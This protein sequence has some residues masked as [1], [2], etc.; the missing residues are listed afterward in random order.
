MTNITRTAWKVQPHLLFLLK[1]RDVPSTGLH[2]AEGQCQSKY[3][4]VELNQGTTNKDHH[5]QAEMEDSQNSTQITG[6]TVVKNLTWCWT[7]QWGTNV[8]K[9][10]GRKKSCIQ[11]LFSNEHSL[12]QAVWKQWICQGEAAT[13]PV[14]KL[15]GLDL[16]TV[17]T[18][19]WCHTH[20]CSSATHPHSAGSMA[21][22]D[23]HPGVQTGPALTYPRCP[24]REQL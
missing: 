19:P 5:K 12:S 17:V 13:F 8:K 9:R 7:W 6:L 14:C 11:Q 15:E 2:R 24:L 18:L 23:F 1:P 21:G 10:N 22:M 4:D 3:S 20:S 16:C